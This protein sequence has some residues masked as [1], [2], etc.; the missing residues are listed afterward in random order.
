MGNG[1]NNVKR[2]L[3]TV[4]TKCNMCPTDVWTKLIVTYLS[5]RVGEGRGI[6]LLSSVNP[7]VYLP[8]LSLGVL[9]ISCDR[10]NFI[11]L[12]YNRK[13]TNYL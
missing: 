10:E 12:L 5:P 8:P 3:N 7:I 6:I 13:S 9:Q 1:R 11:H 4:P 2:N